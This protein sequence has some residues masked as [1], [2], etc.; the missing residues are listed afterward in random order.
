MIYLSNV[1]AGGNTIFPQVKS[2]T[3]HMYELFWDIRIFGYHQGDCREETR[4][5]YKIPISA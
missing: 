4:R 1:Q 3:H 5:A 2:L